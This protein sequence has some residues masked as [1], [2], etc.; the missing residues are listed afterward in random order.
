MQ[1]DQRLGADSGAVSAVVVPVDDIAA[2]AQEEHR[3]F[4]GVFPRQENDA[5]EVVGLGGSAGGLKAL[6]GFF[7]AV[8]G[9]TG[10]AYVVVMHLSPEHESSLAEILQRTTTMPVRQVVE[11]VA[12]LPDHVY[13]ISPGVHLSLTGGNLHVTE[14][15][16]PRGRR[17]A[18]DLFFRTLADSCGTKATAIVLSGG[19]ADGVIGL[20]RIKERG[21]LTIAQE[22]SEAEHQ[23]MPR[24]AI[25]TG[26]VDWVLPVKEMPARL[27][28]FRENARRLQ[29]PPDEAPLEADASQSP[30]DQESCLL[31]ILAF[32]R[33]RTGH[34]FSCY[35]RATVLRR[36]SR[37]MQVNGCQGLAEYLR[38]LRCHAGE[39]GALLQDLLISVTNFFRD[40][41]AFAAVKSL[42]PTLFQDKGPHDQVRVWVAACA[43]G[44][45]AY[46]VAMLL[47]EH[48]E[49]L[50]QPPQIQVFA[51]DI[52]ETAVAAARDGFYPDTIVADVSEEQLHKFF[53][54]EGAGFRV[55]RAL[56][57][58]VL[59]ARH[60]VLKDSPF[61]RLDVVTCR[62]LLIY[63]SRE[64]QQRVFDIF[65]FALKTGGLLF[66]GS[67]ESA[68]E[69]AALFAPLDKKH[70]IY[71]R[72]AA[73]R[74]SAPASAR[75]FVH[76]LDLHPQR[77]TPTSLPLHPAPA[78]SDRSPGTARRTARSQDAVSWGE[79]HF[80][81]VERLSPPSLMVNRA[82]E[83][84]H[85]S[86]HVGVFFQ[87]AGGE[88]STNLL[89]QV[90]PA[91]RSGLRSGL[92]RAFKNSA[93]VE[94]ERVDVEL[95]GG[96]CPVA[97]TLYP[98]PGDHPELMLVVFRKS[99]LANAEEPVHA[100]SPADADI[101]QHLE[102]ELNDMKSQW[103]ET[104]G[105]YETS[106]EELKASNEELQAMNEELRSTTEEL[107]T[108]REELQSINEELTTVNQEL[109]S[110]VDELGRTNSD[111][112][113]LM[114]STDIA[115]IFLDR[116]LR[117]KRYTPSTV[118]LFHIIPTDIGRPLRDL[119]HR[120][121]YPDI[122]K[123]ARLVLERLT[124]VEREAKG[125]DGGWF[126]IRLLPYRTVEDQ[127]AG[128]VL[129]CVD[130]TDR[131]EAG[132]ARRW[133]STIVESSGD[134]I[135]S[136][137]LEGKILS[138]NRGAELLFGYTADE[139]RD[140]N[141]L[142]L[143][144]PGRAEEETQIM[145]ML[146]RGESVES[147]ETVRLRKDGS[148][149]D[150]AISASPVCDERGEVMAATA[151]AQDITIR[152]L[153][154]AELRKAHDLLEDRVASRTR[155]LEE[156]TVQLRRVT[157]E[158]TRSE[159]RERT[160]MAL[161]LHDHVQQLLVSAKMRM[162]GMSRTATPAQQTELGIL[163]SLVEESLESSRSLAVDLSPPVLREGLAAALEWLAQ[164]WMKEKH[165]LEVELHLDHRIDA[166]SEEIRALV[167]LAVRELLFNVVKHAG[168]THAVLELAA[169]D[170]HVLRVSVSDAGKGFE[171]GAHGLGHHKGSGMGLST[172]RDRIHIL[173]GSLSLSNRADHGVDAIL[174][175]PRGADLESKRDDCCE[176]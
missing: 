122:S 146:H 165:G 113:N 29:L 57:E 77:F 63:L 160:R 53:T 104:V 153:A 176:S 171:P 172:V 159:Q 74:A 99:G 11:T 162:Q 8:Q 51:T 132:E 164:V 175:A 22:P 38:Y 161:L 47:C 71:E 101:V 128:V 123:D 64:T 134:A 96:K 154:V 111:L 119:A 150:I 18:V 155:E 75:A 170:D 107:E 145:E 86:E 94:V 6:M 54:K 1:E 3:E 151:I 5:L 149:V 97:I 148:L 129:T 89:R 100:I 10:A 81:M 42:I 78:K 106:G 137:D 136:F 72:R 147:L 121:D 7:G 76:G 126:L 40:R 169:S 61:S 15:N 98:E 12:I 110:K 93:P 46:S 62:N 67:S 157:L 4:D 69:G 140:K 112:Q 55:R 167:F 141:K 56:R 48:A 59:F 31:E 84:L 17:V 108:G 13:V 166:G 135:I 116:E 50:V 28:T 87:P 45:E 60:D 65:H 23:S 66:L 90:H 114:A 118:H 20:K 79:A 33:V 19:D 144:P 130:M 95:S 9:A 39:T 131:K 92:Y 117:I 143:L 120:L 35:K 82:H 37:R 26:M 34:D 124:V 142:L 44:E 24:S 125:T 49:S 14:M 174:L 25:A 52:D 139:M 43:T 156:Q 83:I 88:V 103:R 105:E 102:D 36:L 70:R 152:K 133:L 58:I 91:L 168:V 138:W 2:S 163:V 41:E 32:L 21:G 27:E 73:V 85:L 109:K 158:L 127:I 30:L 80:R 16:G 115:T 68:E 173:G